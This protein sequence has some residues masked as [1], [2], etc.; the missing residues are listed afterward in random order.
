MDL[1]ISERCLLCGVASVLHR[2]EHERRAAPNN[3]CVNAG[4]K[5]AAPQRLYEASV[6]LLPGDDVPTL[7]VASVF[8]STQDRNDRRSAH[9]ARTA[10]E[11]QQVAA[12]ANVASLRPKLRQLDQGVVPVQR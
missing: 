12:A 6:V 8:R 11:C 5:V 7:Q 3:E 9:V 2:V 4:V 10:L 1:V